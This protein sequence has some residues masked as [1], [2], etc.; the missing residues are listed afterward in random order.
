MSVVYC[1]TCDRHIDTDF[2]CDHEYDCEVE[3]GLRCSYCG[4]LWPCPNAGGE[5]YSTSEL[6][7]RVAAQRKRD[8]ASV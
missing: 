1:F 4:E 6:E 2:D 3:S 8:L 7:A 5:H